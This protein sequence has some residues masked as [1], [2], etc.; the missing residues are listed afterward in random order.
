MKMQHFAG[1]FLKSMVF[2][3]MESMKRYDKN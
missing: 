2:L 1:S 3:K